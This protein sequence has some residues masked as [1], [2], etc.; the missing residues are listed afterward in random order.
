MGDLVAATGFVTGP[1]H[2]EWMLTAAGPVLIECAGRPPGDYIYDLVG[3]AYGT[4]PY[5]QLCSLLQGRAIDLPSRSSTTAAVRFLFAER[6]GRLASLQG[7]EAAAACDGV[8]RVEIRS[9]PGAQ[10]GPPTSSWGRL[11]YAIAVGGPDEVEVIA[12]TALDHIQV[13]IRPL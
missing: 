13:E 10:V 3:L 1:L 9:T 2:A 8:V 7:L 4:E 6:E 5:L 11:G 12:Q